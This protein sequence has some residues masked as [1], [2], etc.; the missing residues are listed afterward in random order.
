MHFIDIIGCQLII[1]LQRDCCLQCSTTM[2]QLRWKKI[3]L[4]LDT[5]DLIIA[6]KSPFVAPSLFP[7]LGCAQ[8]TDQGLQSQIMTEFSF[9]G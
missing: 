1:K 9:L 4:S 2:V 7:S 6:M 5:A 8:T 3:T